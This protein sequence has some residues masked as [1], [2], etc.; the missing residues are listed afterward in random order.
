MSWIL[1]QAEDI[2]NRV[3]QQTN[4]AVN[5]HQLRSNSKQSFESS[6]TD[7]DSFSRSKK[8]AENP[9]S[10]VGT[11]MGNTRRSKKQEEADLL[12]YLNSSTPVSKKSDLFSTASNTLSDA[13][14][15]ASSPNMTRSD[16]TTSI[17]ENLASKSESATPRSRTPASASH[18]DDEGLVLVSQRCS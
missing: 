9:I 16:S 7:T 2:L 8:S 4:A 6:N 15:T 10:N 1:K 12:E 5:Q 11:T 18:E 14:R 17:N 3:D 13:T